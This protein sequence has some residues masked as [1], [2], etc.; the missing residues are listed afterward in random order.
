MGHSPGHQMDTSTNTFG[1]IF[2]LRKYK[3]KNDKA[4]IYAR[5]TVDG[6]R[7]DL[8]IKC[9]IEE[10][11]WNSSRGMAKGSREEI[12]NLNRHLE[13]VRAKLVDHY[14]NMVL[15]GKLA[16]ADAIKNQFLDIDKRE[17]TLCKLVEYHNT[18]MKD[19]LA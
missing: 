5:I 6:R 13:Q 17:H 10:S 14:Q 2:Y 19:T 4:P 9:S 18:K 1:V 3:A 7:V 8:S 15:Q 12:R 16:T 11:S